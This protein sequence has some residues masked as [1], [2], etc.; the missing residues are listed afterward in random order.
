MS[1]IISSTYTKCDT[2]EVSEDDEEDDEE[3]DD[4]S[5]DG[6]DDEEVESF[7]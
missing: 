6:S 5:E 7:L 2:D 4:G 1:E 3:M